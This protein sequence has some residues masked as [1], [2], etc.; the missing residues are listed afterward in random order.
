MFESIR[1]VRPRFETFKGTS[2][3]YYINMDRVLVALS[4][5]VQEY[6]VRHCPCFDRSNVATSFSSTIIYQNKNTI[7]NV[8]FNAV[9]IKP[10]LP[11]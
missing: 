8:E 2:S 10:D 9:M 7:D 11:R 3:F 1:Y 6:F 5:L 4:L